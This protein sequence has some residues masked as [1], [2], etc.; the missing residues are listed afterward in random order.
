MIPALLEISR[1][2]DVPDEDVVLWLCSW[3]SLF[4]E[5]DRPVDHPDDP[6]TLLAAARDEFGAIR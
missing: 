6:Q 3:S 2:Y 1:R 5:H 4:A